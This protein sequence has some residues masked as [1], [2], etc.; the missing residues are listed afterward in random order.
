MVVPYGGGAV[1]LAEYAF[2]ALAGLVAGVI[3]GI[4]G[5]GT[6]ASFPALLAVGI[7]PLSANVTSTV[8]IWTGYLGGVGGFRENLRSQGPRIRR[9]TVAAVGGALIGSLLLV[10]TSEEAFETLAPILVFA[11]CGLFA[12][13]PLV[14]RAA[15]RRGA[16]VERPGATQAGTA[17]GGL[18]GAYFGAGLG[19]VLL[20]V[21]GAT[22][23]DDL[24]TLNGV[25][26]VLA[27]FVNSIA[28][29]V[30]VFAAPVEWDAAATLAVTALVG[31]FLGA[32]TSLKLPPA[33]LRAVVIA[34]GVA[35]GVGLLL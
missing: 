2:L 17:V 27:M 9:L 16:V 34:L 18:Y 7:E 1:T 30:F 12:V 29:I 19:V 15:E 5:G 14:K 22:S 33:V 4:A 28:V 25:R 10:V 13:Q 6:M 31:G 3:N 26:A 23:R 8:G 20:A 32:R 21:L 24:H 11:A 35:A